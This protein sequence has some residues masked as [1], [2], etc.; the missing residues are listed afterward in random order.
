MTA[1]AYARA[2][3]LALGPLNEAIGLGPPIVA[4]PV[5]NGPRAIS[6]KSV[7]HGFAGQQIRAAALVPNRLAA[8][9]LIPEGK[10]AAAARWP[11]TSLS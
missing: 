2:D 1:G 8:K 9:P 10:A 7:E 11:G 5:P 3:T 4:V 6:E